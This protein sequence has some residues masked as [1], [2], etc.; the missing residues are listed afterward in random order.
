MDKQKPKSE[1]KKEKLSETVNK[2]SRSAVVGTIIG[3]FIALTPFLWSLYEGV[4]DEV[5]WDTFLGTYESKEWE[6]AQ[7]AMW[8]LTGKLV[9]LLLLLIWFFTNKNWW[10]H[11]LLVPIIMYIFQIYG[12]I[13]GDVNRIDELQLV[14]MLPVTALVIPSIY[15]IRA[16][17]FNKINEADKTLKELEDDFRMKPTGVWNTIKQYF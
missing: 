3:T 7:Y 10:Y 9:P 14:Y 15:L 11:A 5:F 12:T 16:K 17:M 8:V 2:I 1:N 6:S 4:P 13:Q